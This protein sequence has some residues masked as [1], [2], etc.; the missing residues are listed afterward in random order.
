M[1]NLMPG[2]ARWIWVGIFFL[3]LVPH[4]AHFVRMHGVH[5]FWHLGHVLMGIGMAYMFL[6]P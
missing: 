2:W 4:V 5:R 3:I 6:P 1:V